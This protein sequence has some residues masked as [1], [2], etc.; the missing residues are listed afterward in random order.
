MKQSRSPRD[1][2]RFWRTVLYWVAAA[3]AV[4]LL[5]IGV[6]IWLGLQP[7]QP[8]ASSSGS[9]TVL[10]DCMNNT[11]PFANPTTTPTRETEQNA[12]AYLESPGRT[13]CYESLVPKAGAIITDALDRNQDNKFRTVQ[14]YAA[15]TNDVSKYQGWGFIS[16]ADHSIYAYVWWNNGKIDY[17]DHP[18]SQIGIRNS[19]ITTPCMVQ[20]LGHRE[21]PLNYWTVTTITEYGVTKVGNTDGIR[22]NPWS[23]D[24]YSPTSVAELAQLDAEV[25]TLLDLDMSSWFG[26][27]WYQ[28]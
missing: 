5:V 12:V 16:T 28:A 1:R 3:I 14:R 8:H 23:A 26:R 7:H 4:V 21:A 6:R 17:K 19:D 20:L 24:H 2:R 15:V 9:A 18:I 10:N 25:Y 11:V 27:N 13:K 22:G